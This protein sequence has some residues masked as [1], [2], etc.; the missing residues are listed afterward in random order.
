MST[1]RERGGGE[2]TQEETYEESQQEE[3]G[4]KR[5]NY[6]ATGTDTFPEREVNEEEDGH[7]AH[8]QRCLDGAHV[9]QSVR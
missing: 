2:E 7:E 5:E 3:K 9:V 1:G 4:M 6:F 8:G